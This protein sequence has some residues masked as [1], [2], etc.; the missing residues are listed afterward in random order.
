MARKHTL[1][2]T[3]KPTID[4]LVVVVPDNCSIHHVLKFKLPDNFM[5]NDGFGEEKKSVDFMLTAH[6]IRLKGFSSN[7]VLDFKALRTH[8]KHLFPERATMNLFLLTDIALK[9]QYYSW[10]DTKH[11]K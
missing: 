8:G 2:E 9:N 7:L 11:S 3:T 5:Y 1:H 10:S 4:K 6:A